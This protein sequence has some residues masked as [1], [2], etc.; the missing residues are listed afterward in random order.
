VLELTLPWPPSIN[1]Y[2]R[3]FRGRTVISAKGRQWQKDAMAELLLQGVPRNKLSCRLAISIDQYP[4]DRRRRDIDNP[5]KVANDLLV[6]AGV[7]ADD[8]LIDA[9]SIHRHDPVAPGKFVIRIRE[10]VKMQDLR[11]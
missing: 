2:W 4:P 11:C 8:S 6:Y 7:I 1:H 3:N 5:V 9:L 10:Y